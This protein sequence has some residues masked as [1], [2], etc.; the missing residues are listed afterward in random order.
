MEVELGSI[1]FSESPQA[2]KT[3]WGGEKKVEYTSIVQ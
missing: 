3:A 1:N 2:W